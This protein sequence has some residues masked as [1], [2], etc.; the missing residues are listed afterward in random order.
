MVFVRS[1]EK[2]EEKIPE[3]LGEEKRKNQRGP[4]NIPD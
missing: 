1:C 3:E 4:N 2:E